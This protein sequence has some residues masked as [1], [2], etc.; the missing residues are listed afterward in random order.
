LLGD[1]RRG[2]GALR[3]AS[4]NV[5]GEIGSRRRGSSVTMGENMAGSQ[6]EG[7]LVSTT[8]LLSDPA[9]NAANSSLQVRLTAP[10]PATG[11]EL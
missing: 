8:L 10:S 9:A 6:V 1:G 5:S 7:R 3:T 11:D 4:L 2:D